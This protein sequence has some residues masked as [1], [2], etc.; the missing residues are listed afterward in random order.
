MSSLAG[1]E[2]PTRDWPLGM[3]RA[4]GP[5]KE[6]MMSEPDGPEGRTFAK[7]PA[8]R[9]AA[10]TTPRHLTEPEPPA[11]RP[12]SPARYADGRTLMALQRSAGN[13]AVLR[14]L[15]RRQEAQQL[16]HR[17][18]A[19]RLEGRDAP[20]PSLATVRYVRPVANPLA[21]ELGRASPL[22]SRAA[23]ARAAAPTVQRAKSDLG[24]V[25]TAAEQLEGAEGPTFTAVTRGKDALDPAKM[26]TLE[27]AV[28]LARE[29]VPRA[30]ADAQAVNPEDI[31]HQAKLDNAFVLY[32]DA[33]VAA[34]GRKTY[35]AL[36]A[37]VKAKAGGDPAKI[38][39]ATDAYRQQKKAQDK[40]KADTKTAMDKP[41][42]A[43]AAGAAGFSAPTAKIT[44]VTTD[45]KAS[46]LNV[47]PKIETGLSQDQELVDVNPT[48]V[49]KDELG[50]VSPWT[51]LFSR[52]RIHLRFDLLDKRPAPE[53][54]R[55]LVHEASHK[56]AKT[57]D[58]AYFENQFKVAG[59]TNKQARDNADSYAL[60]VESF[61]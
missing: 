12:L 22:G 4:F 9:E 36:T 7:R 39:A 37:V 5:N 10:A 8:D 57:D 14:Y 44:A 6:R 16:G 13:R 54:A 38:A 46:L 30:V 50:Y 26:K 48:K 2:G 61:A 55:L 45:T 24:D 51:H 40:T 41:T 43:G 58:H 42:G 3:L 59:I 34:E 29:W 47:L 19:Q 31:A 20:P 15:G 25:R 56:Y 17:P 23:S 35:S 33:A 60:Y 1:E 11:G 49:D 53:I 52:G 21:A 28:G 32:Q 27:S 18:V